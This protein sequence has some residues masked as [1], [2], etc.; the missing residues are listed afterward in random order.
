MRCNGSTWSSCRV[1][2]EFDACITGTHCFL[3]KKVDNT[4]DML[5]KLNRTK[6]KD[7]TEFSKLLAWSAS[8]FNFYKYYSINRPHKRMLISIDVL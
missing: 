7:Q 8:Y 5:R 6:A 2:N 3:D 1:S 4:S